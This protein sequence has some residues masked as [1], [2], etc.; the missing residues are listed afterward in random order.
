MAELVDMLVSGTSFRNGVGV[1]VLPMN[2]DHSKNV[3]FYTISYN[4]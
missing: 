4:Y 3:H 2:Y 1:R